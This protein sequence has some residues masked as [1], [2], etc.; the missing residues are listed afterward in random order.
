MVKPMRRIVT[1]H[2]SRG[3][4][5][6]L[7]DEVAPNN[8]RPP[9]FAG[10]GITELWETTTTPASNKG[11]DDAVTRPVRLTPPRN[12]S[13]FR[14][15]DF[16]PDKSVANVDMSKIF[17]AMGA[18]H[19]KDKSN[20]RH[21]GFHKTNTVD[22]ALIL[23]GEIWAMMDEGET[24][25]KAGDCLV[26]RGTNHSWSNRSDKICRVAFILIDADPMP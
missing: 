1:G 14:I 18:G 25:M 22:Y 5:V 26:Q 7:R 13:I 15:V 20:P 23:D 8:F 17:E 4:S 19:T 2:N 10:G 11:D 12:G 21:P 6:I 16:P 24:L 9:Q 3:K